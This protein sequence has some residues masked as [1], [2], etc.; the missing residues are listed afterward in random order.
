MVATETTL[1]VGILA[2]NSRYQEA[3]L[4]DSIGSAPLLAVP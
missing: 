2:T 4:R 1:T 3:L